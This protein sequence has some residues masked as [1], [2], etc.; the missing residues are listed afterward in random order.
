MDS[1]K[2]EEETG[3]KMENGIEDEKDKKIHRKNPENERQSWHNWNVIGILPKIAVRHLTYNT[4]VYT[5]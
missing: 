2:I 5:T 3:N 1:E 4:D